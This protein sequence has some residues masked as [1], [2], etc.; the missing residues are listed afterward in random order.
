MPRKELSAISPDRKYGLNWDSKGYIDII[1]IETGEELAWL[2]DNIPHWIIEAAF[3]R[4]MRRILCLNSDGS[5]GVWLMPRT[6]KTNT[7]MRNI[8]DCVLR[9]RDIFL[10]RREDL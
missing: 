2:Y 3:S 8:I 4:D 6:R 1:E 10:L 5:V 7:S 9:Q